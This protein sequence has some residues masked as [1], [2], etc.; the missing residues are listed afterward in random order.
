MTTCIMHAYCFSTSPPCRIL[1]PPLL[2]EAD[3]HH[4]SAGTASGSAFIY[5]FHYSKNISVCNTKVASKQL[6]LPLLR[7]QST[8]T[9][10]L[11]LFSVIQLLYSIRQ[12]MVLVKIILRQQKSEASA[13][14]KSGTYMTT[15]PRHQ[16]AT[17]ISM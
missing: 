11:P 13:D 4:L 2:L 6:L 3:V 5:I 1:A 12:N 17:P 15:T 9:P 10:S 8:N 7:E 14:K 16:L